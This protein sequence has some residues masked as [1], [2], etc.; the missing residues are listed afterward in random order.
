M[1]FYLEKL[2]CHRCF[3]PSFVMKWLT[4]HRMTLLA[5]HPFLP[6]H[7]LSPFCACTH[8]FAIV[9]IVVAVFG[10]NFTVIGTMGFCVALLP[11]D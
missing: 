11:S 5:S 4:A 7:F 10:L 8:D 9:S 2:V 6:S 3:H 1:S